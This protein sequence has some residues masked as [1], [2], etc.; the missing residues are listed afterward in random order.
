MNIIIP[1]CGTG[2]RFTNAGYI[3]PKPLIDVL[4]KKMIFHV[5]DKLRY[6]QDD[7]IF[8]IYHI[9]LNDFDFS[10]IIINRYPNIHL[11]PISHRTAGAA[12]TV[13]FGIEYILNSN[14]SNNK[15]TLIIDCDTIY[16]INILKKLRNIDTNAVIYFED[17]KNNPIY[18]YIKIKDNIITDIIEKEKIS[19][20]ANTGAYYFKDIYELKN[21]CEYIIKNNIKFKNEY[22][23]SS[24]IKNMLL[25]KHIFKPIQIN[26]NHYISLGTP[27]E[28]N[29]YTENHI[30]FLFDLDGTLIKTDSIY[31]KVWATILEKYNIILSDKIFNNK[32]AGNNDKV[33]VEQLA[34]TNY[35]LEE[36]S[37]LKDE[38]FY[39]CLYDMQVIDGAIEF[40]KNI[41]RLGH[42]ICIVTNC[43]RNICK[44]ILDH[45]NITKYVSHIIIGNE[46]M[47][48]KPYPHP[49]LKA[50]QLLNTVPDKCIIFED[51]KPGLLSALSVSP[52]KIIGINNGTNENIL[53]E[54][55]IQNYITSYFE[56]DANNLL[57]DIDINNTIKKMVYSSLSNKYIIKNI[58]IDNAKL[59]GG[60]I[61]DVIRVKIETDTNV[62]DC[63]LKYENDY[64]TSLTKMA[65][66]LGLFDREY[67][68]YENI[69]H[70]V[71][72]HIPK[73]IG[74]I[75]DNNF[76]SKGI[77][78]ENINKENFYLGLD[79]N[80]ESIDV[81]LK[82]I[83]QLAKLHSS[84]WNKDLS[85]SFQNLKK[86]NDS[87]FNPVWSDFIKEKWPLFNSKWNYLINSELKCKLEKIVNNFSEIQEYLSKDNLTLCHGDV[88]SGN[89][90]YKKISEKS[91]IPYFIDW[92]YIANGKGVQ[93][94]VF[95]IIESF[96]LE[97]IKEYM[98]IFKQ[99]YYLKLKEYGISY[100][101]LDEYI[102]DF[103]YS[104]YYFPLFVAIWFGTTP[105][106]ELIDISFPSR[107][108][109][110]FLYCIN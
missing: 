61:S 85:K 37:K 56:L 48:P 96:D 26:R 7:K 17:N 43:N 42:S 104:L 54:L 28:L 39:K 74:T 100:Y 55:K 33:A 57:K 29:I 10:N 98:P 82:V 38:L 13:L 69:S 4:G 86:H 76:I 25:N 12:E 23:M 75:K 63:V 91:Y 81:S 73:Y 30:S 94:I 6:N 36:I 51:S 78:L 49:Y 8:I 109:N 20:N 34:I 46:C 47:Y 89:I 5:L 62:L 99:Y 77:I 93:D 64:T 41:Y 1:L 71:N 27:E 102:K 110:K 14:L 16:N 24:V 3:Q 70:Y 45:I 95:F 15:N 59:K 107:F 84:F 2:T 101:T 72:I 66:K 106:N 87:L 88:K 97:H 108:I 18:S 40:I 52:K 19:N 105:N 68:F 22:Y 65:Y 60:Y 103:E 79:L 80:K 32:I 9:S 83:E 67:Y 50:I 35:N 92:Q 90:F 11:I 21:N 31:Y 53:K 58:S 44:S